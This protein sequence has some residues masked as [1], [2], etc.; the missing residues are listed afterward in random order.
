MST[1]Y[2]VP[3]FPTS[4]APLPASESPPV[5]RQHSYLQR[6]VGDFLS[7]KGNMVGQREPWTGKDT[8][9]RTSR[10]QASALNETLAQ[11]EQW[12]DMR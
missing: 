8:L 5:R 11:A 2:P 3:P 1:Q 10:L 12:G 6:F 7:Q 4:G 9:I